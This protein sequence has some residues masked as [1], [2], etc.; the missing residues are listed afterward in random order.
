MY[1]LIGEMYLFVSFSGFNFIINNYSNRI[2]NLCQFDIIQS[3]N[4]KIPPRRVIC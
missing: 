3:F 4:L 2:D 1:T